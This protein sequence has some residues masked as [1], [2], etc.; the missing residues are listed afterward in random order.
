MKKI[1]L[2]V[3]MPSYNEENNI[4]RGV[5][6]VVRGYLSKKDFKWEVIIS[7]DGSTDQSKNLVKDQIKKWKNFRLLENKH[8]GKPYAL[9]RGIESSKGNFILF[10]DMDLSTP[11]TEL[12]KMLPFIKKGFKVVI[13]SRGMNRKNFPLYR[14]LGAYVF[15]TIRKSFVLSDIND[16]QCGFKVFDRKI[17]NEAFPKLE[18]FAKQSK[19]RGWTVTSYDVEL[20]HIIE[21]S[22]AKI[23]E[24]KVNWRDEDT[25]K[26]KGGS[27]QRYIKES[28]DMLM[29][30]TRV[31]INDMKGLY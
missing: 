10:C 6:K 4:K 8:G 28:K 15:A 20:L 16:T 23:K 5:L 27:L 14:K 29:Q 3:I 25:S 31:K 24:V 13:G 17:V 30:I 11:I 1:F 2:S 19:A 21:K 7:D 26:S 18:F 22:G 9:L 12:D